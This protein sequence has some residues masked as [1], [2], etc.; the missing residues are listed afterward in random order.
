M[1]GG[2][3]FLERKI[4]GDHVFDN[5]NL[6]SNKMTTDIAFMLFKKT[7]FDTILT[8]V[9][10]RSIDRMGVIKLSLPK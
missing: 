6:E 7:D 5:Q 9:G 8:C 4:G 3:K 1:E 10:V 2:H